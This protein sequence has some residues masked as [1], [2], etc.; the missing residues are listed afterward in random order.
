LTP[1]LSIIIPAYNEESRLPST[2]K[3]VTSY[4]ARRD[5]SFYEIIVVDDGSKDGTVAAV[6][7]FQ[8]QGH[9][10]RILKNPGNRGKGY[11]VRH[12]MLE[13]GAEWLLFSD[14]DLSTPIEEFE[15]LYAAVS[16]EVPIAVGSRALDRSLI[17][18]HQS[19]FRERA[20]QLFNFAMRLAL[21]L[22][23]HDT[24]CGFKLFH[25]DAARE[26]FSRQRLERFSFDAEILFIARK[27]GYRAAEVPVRWNNVEGTKV[28]MWS[29]ARSF[30]DLVTI[31]WNAARGIYR[32]KQR[33]Q[34][35]K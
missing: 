34:M 18:V 28:G 13:A 26:I 16:G 35:E 1:S 21:G 32:I 14:A 11:A 22:E 5:W 19:P 33:M 6:E 30:L 12:G 3:T 29:G 17:G 7:A 31:R 15:K 23:L 25:R 24:Q 8:G 2:L 27:L 10:I 9:P 4:L 20:G